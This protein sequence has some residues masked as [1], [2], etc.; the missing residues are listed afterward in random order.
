MKGD[1]DFVQLAIQEQSPPWKS[2]HDYAVGDICRESSAPDASSYKC[3]QAHTS[4]AGNKPPNETY[5]TRFY[6]H[7]ARWL[8]PFSGTASQHYYG[9]TLPWRMTSGA[10][11]PADSPQTQFWVQHDANNERPSVFVAEGTHA[12]YFRHGIFNVERSPDALRTMGTQIQYTTVGGMDV[13]YEEAEATAL[14]IH[15]WT[16]PDNDF[17]NWMGLWGFKDT[18]AGAPFDIEDRNGP[19]GVNRRF[20]V[21]QPPGL[22][23]LVLR[24]NP[25]QFNN[26]CRREVSG[27]AEDRTLID[28]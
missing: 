6:N 11:G 23:Q 19:P 2:G 15:T 22:T 8:R 26:N 25:R 24:P 14:T 9:Q 16:L 1:V 18:E 20:A 7:K 3:N 10:D 17:E 4:A 12:T 21:G 28:P 13:S 27:T 5:W